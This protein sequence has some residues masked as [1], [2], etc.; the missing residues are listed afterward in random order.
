V[1]VIA[2]EA[3]TATGWV[4]VDETNRYWRYEAR[5]GPWATFDVHEVQEIEWNRRKSGWE[6]RRPHR[7]RYA[8][9]YGRLEEGTCWAR[10]RRVI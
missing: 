7:C 5:F 4:S 10:G 8:H 6:P 9:P 3:L 1:A 2:P